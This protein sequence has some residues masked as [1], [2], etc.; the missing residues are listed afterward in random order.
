MKDN[1]KNIVASDILMLILLATII[2][3]MIWEGGIINAWIIC[4][5]FTLYSRIR[6]R[7]NY[8]LFF[9]IIL[10]IILDKLELDNKQGGK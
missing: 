6:S 9:G 7:Y 8:R 5:Y 2:F 4:I 1:A 10:F 3:N